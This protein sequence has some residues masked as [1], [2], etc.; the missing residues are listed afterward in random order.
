MQIYIFKMYGFFYLRERVEWE[1]FGISKDSER[2][3]IRHFLYVAMC[4][5]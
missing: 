3:K 1:K 5:H 2:E 4:Q